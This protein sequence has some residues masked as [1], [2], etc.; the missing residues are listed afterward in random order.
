MLATVIEGPQRSRVIRSINEIHYNFYFPPIS[1][2][3]YKIMK[4]SVNPIEMLIKDMG[5]REFY[6]EDE[7][8]FQSF[9]KGSKGFETINRW[10]T[11]YNFEDKYGFDK[12]RARVT[13]EGDLFG[14]QNNGYCG[15]IIKTRIQSGKEDLPDLRI[16]LDYFKERMDKVSNWHRYTFL[17][18]V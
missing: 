11:I 2:S 3:D 17:N 1:F 7:Q 4:I 15:P 8:R 18:K 5:G 10:K 12:T 6:G 16:H 14:K 13:V 9:K